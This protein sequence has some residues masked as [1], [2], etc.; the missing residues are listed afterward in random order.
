MVSISMNLVFFFFQAE[1]GIRDIGAGVQTCA[2][3]ILFAGAVNSDLADT[4]GNF[5]NRTLTFTARRFGAAVPEGGRPGPAEH[6]LAEDLAQAVARYT[7]HLERLQLRKAALQ[8]REIWALG[9]GYL[10]RTAPWT[11]IRDDPGRAACSLRTAIN[12]LRVHAVLAAPVIP[13]TSERILAALGVE[14]TGWVSQDTA[15][16]LERVRA[17]E[18]YTVPDVLFRKISQDDIAAWT[19]RFGGA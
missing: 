8:L 19:D 13:S 1:D 11:A 14:L 9:N 7:E 17:G 18:A 12:L 5:V 4:L 15:A 2:L 3:P 16:E 6:Q 10:E